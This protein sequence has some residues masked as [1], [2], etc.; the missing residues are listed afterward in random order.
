ME[1]GSHSQGLGASLTAGLK[2]QCPAAPGPGLPRSQ[3]S[4]SSLKVAPAHACPLCCVLGLFCPLPRAPP[5]PL[6]SLIL[7]PALA[8][9]EHKVASAPSMVTCCPWGRC[10]QCTPMR[11]AGE[12]TEQV[13]GEEG[14][15]VHW[16]PSPVQGVLCVSRVGIRKGRRDCTLS[17]ACLCIRRP[18]PATH[19]PAGLKC[20]VRFRA[21]TLQECTDA[22]LEGT[23]LRGRLWPLSLWATFPWGGSPG[24]S[25]GM[26]PGLSSS[27]DSQLACQASKSVCL[28]LPEKPQ[29]L[30][31]QVH[32]PHLGVG[33]AAPPGANWVISVCRTMRG[34]GGGSSQPSISVQK[35]APC[36]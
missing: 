15:Q 26:Q 21:R 34:E 3:S 16:A 14:T 22:K 9:W 33:N 10:R 25:C 11:Q 2:Q 29:F 24:G 32:C 6:T 27:L 5:L 17:S 28:H 31:S 12:T 30:I 35:T 20:R 1:P 7:L 18:L 13:P 8:S 4:G 23:H 19:T 36:W